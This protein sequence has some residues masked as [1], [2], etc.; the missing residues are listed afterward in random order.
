LTQGNR[1]CPEPDPAL[2]RPPRSGCCWTSC[3]QPRGNATVVGLDPRRDKAALHRQIGYLLGELMFPGR[4]K[5]FL[6]MVR[7]ASVAGQAIFMSSHV[8]SEV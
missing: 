5:A 2:E 7:D 6:A 4:D 1:L 8:L 3:A